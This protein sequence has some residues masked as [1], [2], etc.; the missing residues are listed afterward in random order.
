MNNTGILR[1]PLL[2]V[3]LDPVTRVSLWVCCRTMDG[4]H[5]WDWFLDHFLKI[6]SQNPQ[7]LRFNSFFP[8]SPRQLPLSTW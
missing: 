4:G 1:L 2:I 6:S 8:I 7:A 3:I 5:T